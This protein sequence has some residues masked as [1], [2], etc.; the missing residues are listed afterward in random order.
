MNRKTSVVGTDQEAL[1]RLLTIHAPPEPRILDVTHN[2]GVMWQ[3]LPYQVHRSDIDP[4]LYQEGL[5]DTVADFRSLP[6]GDGSFDVIVFDP[7]HLT[8]AGGTGVMGEWHARYGLD[9]TY[10]QATAPSTLFEPFL[11]EA[12]RVLVQD[13]V[14]LAKICDQVHGRAYQWQ[15]VD[16]I[17]AARARGFT[18]C[19]MVLSI[20]HGRGGLVDPR[21]KRVYH[22][23]QVHTYW[24]VLRNGPSCMSRHAPTVERVESIGMFAEAVA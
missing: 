7:P 4:A 9:K 8:H 10:S 5:T 1:V 14:I 12:G 24:L 21:W 23:R 3:R 19:D 6:F 11:C 2:R 15:H 13:G 18:P 22:V 16:L 20:H 17:V